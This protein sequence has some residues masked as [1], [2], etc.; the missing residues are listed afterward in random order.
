MCLKS[1]FCSQDTQLIWDPIGYP[2]QRIHQL[3]VTWAESGSMPKY[4][5]LRNHETSLNNESLRTL[6]TEVEVIVNSRPLTIE[7][8]N[9]PTSPM[10]L[11]PANLLTSK[12]KIIIPPP[13]NFNQPDIYSRRQ[14][15]RIQEGFILRTNFGQGG[16]A[17]P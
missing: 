2:S 3:L 9:D 5:I 7:T 10:P 8:L 17:N 11:S 14:W 1:S 6:V 4:T 15:R 12:T 13:D 16:K